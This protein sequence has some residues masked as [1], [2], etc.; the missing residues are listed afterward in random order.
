MIKSIIMQGIVKARLLLFILSL[1]VVPLGTYF[2]I[3]FAKGYR[4]DLRQGQFKPTGL[5]VATSFPDGAQIYV[6]GQLKSA[7]DNTVNLEPGEYDVEFK[8]DGYHPWKKH[9]R[10]QAEIVTQAVGFLFP[11]VPSLKAITSVGVSAPSLSPEGNRIIFASRE[12]TLSK[13]FILDLNES[14]LG[15]L[16]R[17]ARQ[18]YSSPT[19]DFSTSR[20]IWSPDS[21][22]IMAVATPSAYLLDLNSQNLSDVSSTTQ[23]VMSRWKS[24]KQVRDQQRLSTLPIKLQEILSASA[25]DV[26]WSPEENKILYTATASAVIPDNLIRQLPGS[27]TQ[28]QSRTLEPGGVYVYDLEEDRNFRITS[29]QVPTPTPSIKPRRP[30]PAP[31]PITAPRTIENELGYHHPSGYS[32]FPT[33]SHLL[34]IEGNKIIVTEYDNQNPTVVYAGPMEANV[35]FPYPSAKQLVIL[36]NLTPTISPLNNLYAISL[37]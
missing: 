23:Q 27:S 29:V 10:V 28:P 34:H 11:T 19:I 13:L 1:V 18:V 9:V 37:R 5:L 32:W 22:Q 7:T 20:L 14:P 16:N 30:T 24:L 6:N 25:T 4:P 21:R 3:L 33:S 15:L 12:G 31:N 36:T 17:E 35:A 26:S 2:I 8:K